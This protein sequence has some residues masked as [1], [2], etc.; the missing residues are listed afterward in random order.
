MY[1]HSFFLTFSYV[2][3]LKITVFLFVFYVT[4]QRKV[5]HNCEVVELYSTVR[6]SS[7]EHLGK[8]CFNSSSESPQAANEKSG[9]A[10]VIPTTGGRK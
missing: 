3:T 8:H 9:K 10:L 5:A 6:V 1:I 7:F 4:E 2:T